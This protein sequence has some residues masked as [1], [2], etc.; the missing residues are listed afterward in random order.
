MTMTHLRWPLLVFTSSA[1]LYCNYVAFKTYR[2]KIIE[3]LQELSLKWKNNELTEEAIFAAAKS[4]VDA[5]TGSLRQIMVSNGLATVLLLAQCCSLLKSIN[6][7]FPSRLLCTSA[8]IG[9]VSFYQTVQ[10]L[11]ECIRLQRI[12][13]KIV[14]HIIAKLDAILTSSFPN[15]ILYSVV[16]ALIRDI[17]EDHRGN[18]G[19]DLNVKGDVEPDPNPHLKTFDMQSNVFRVPADVKDDGI[20]LKSGVTE[21]KVPQPDSFLSTEKSKPADFSSATESLQTLCPKSNVDFV[22]HG[23]V[24]QSNS[25]EPE[26][27]CMAKKILLYQ[28][29]YIYKTFPIQAKGQ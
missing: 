3:E 6:R 16:E 13:S 24:L 4:V 12:Q 21:H 11:L 28:I 19:D 29:R 25:S 17:S 7:G 18:Q 8:I 9:S 20:L 10:S 26:D 22:K 14:V 23:E 15:I 2:L 27:I 5:R 1:A